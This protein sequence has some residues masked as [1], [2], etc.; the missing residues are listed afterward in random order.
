MDVERSDL[1]AVSPASEP[2]RL[3]TRAEA[4]RTLV[5][6]RR[7]VADIVAHSRRL[8]AL[9]DEQL[10]LARLPGRGERLERV[11]AELAEVVAALRALER[12]LTD[13]GCVLKDWER[14]LVD[15]PAEHEGRRVWLCW[16]L[17]E[18]TVG[19]W[20]EWEAGFAGRRPIGPDFA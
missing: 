16:Q 7:I 2:A 12:E 8:L 13:I 20:H 17:G 1:A 5:L 14:G 3:F 6:V 4:E 18:P 10:E 9:R 11:R 19:H 15:F